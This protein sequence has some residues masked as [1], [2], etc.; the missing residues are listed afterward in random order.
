MNVCKQTFRKLC[1]YITREFFGLRMQS[2]QGIIFI[3]T[4]TYS[5]NIKSALVYI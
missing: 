5:E 4:Q 1:E 3:W 2:F